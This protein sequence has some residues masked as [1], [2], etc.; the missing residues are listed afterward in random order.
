MVPDPDHRPSIERV[1]EDAQTQ[2]WYEDQ[3]LYNKI[4]DAREAQV[5]GALTIDDPV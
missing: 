2:E 3:I 4:F 1:I 5:G